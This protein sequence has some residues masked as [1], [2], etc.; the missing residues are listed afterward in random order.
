MKHQTCFAR[1]NYTPDT[2]FPSYSCDTNR[3]ARKWTR[4]KRVCECSTSQ[5]HNISKWNWRW[6]KAV[7]S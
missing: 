1:H 4:C 2:Y 5:R 3:A 7:Q 6:S